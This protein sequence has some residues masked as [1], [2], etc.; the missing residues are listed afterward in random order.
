[1]TTL[2]TVIDDHRQTAAL[3]LI[4]RDVGPGMIDAWL[5]EVAQRGG[6]RRTPVEYRQYL[7]RFRDDVLHPQG[8]TLLEADPRH[9]HAFAYAPGPSGRQPAA[10]TVNVRLSALRSFYDFARRMKAVDVN[11]ADDVKRPKRKEPT[12][13]GL[14]VDQLRTLFDAIPQ[15]DAGLRDRAVILTVLY[16][17]LR[18]SEVLGLTAGRLK[19]EDTPT[20]PRT[21]YTVRVKGGDERNREMPPPAVQAISSYWAQAHGL[22]LE[23]IDTDTRLFPISSIGF[24]A[25]LKRYALKAG[26][27]A[28]KPHDLRHTAAKLRR[29]DG[30]SLEDVQALLG[31]K[32]IATTAI[33]IG[34]L[35]GKIDDGWQGVARLLGGR[36]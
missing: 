16:S 36:E 7:E 30:A 18:R 10:S 4:R 9:L 33:Y 23:Q 25:N 12:P 17:G 11:P 26:L 28:V 8:L 21:F 15:T 34:R 20:G 31:H 14:T 6:S 19:R 5:A 35:E 1:M 2:Q 29:L 22:T 3:D 24:Y 32:S 13:R 27:G